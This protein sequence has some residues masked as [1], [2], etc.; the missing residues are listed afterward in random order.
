MS[1]DVSSDREFLVVVGNNAT[2]SQLVW[3][4]MSY[5]TDGT[6]GGYMICCHS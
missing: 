4:L 6:N 3:Y 2:N 1:W 5:L